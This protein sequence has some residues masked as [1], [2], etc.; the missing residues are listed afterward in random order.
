MSWSWTCEGP[1]VS[2]SK[3]RVRRVLE[4][5]EKDAKFLEE[6]GVMDYSLLLV[7]HRTC[8]S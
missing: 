4:Y 3:L 1:S 5:L 6:Q 7:G 2:F 8:W